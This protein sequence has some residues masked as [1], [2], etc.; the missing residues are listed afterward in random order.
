VLLFAFAKGRGE[1]H[2]LLL[3]RTLQLLPMNK[4]PSPIFSS[5]SV[6]T[7]ITVL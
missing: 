5:T 4:S 3:L 7:H 6:H 2:H 1:A